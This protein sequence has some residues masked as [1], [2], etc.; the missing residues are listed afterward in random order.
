MENSYLCSSSKYSLLCSLASCIQSAPYGKLQNE[1]FW[2]CVQD[3][4]LIAGNFQNQQLH[5]IFQKSRAAVRKGLQVLSIALEKCI[6][7]NQWVA[8]NIQQSAG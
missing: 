1:L 6:P 3:I 2:V 7:S 8:D 4:V 5:L